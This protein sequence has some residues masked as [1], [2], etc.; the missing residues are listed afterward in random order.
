MKVIRPNCRVQFTAEDIDFILEVLGPRAGNNQT[1]VRL[2]ADEEARDLLLDDEAL[3]RAVLEQPHCLRVSTH[4]YFYLLVRHVLRRAHVLDRGVADYVAEILAE[5]SRTERMRYVARGHSQPLDYFVD[6][7][8]ALHQADEFTAFYLRAHI[9]DYSLFL[10][11][12]FPEHIRHRAAQRGAPDLSYYEQLGR[13]NYRAARDHRLASRYA[14]ADIFDVL[15]ERFQT[16]RLALNDLG[17]RLLLLGETDA[18]AA[19]LRP[20]SP[21]LGI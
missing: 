18:A 8:A 15:S 12:V 19:K 6:L 1:L 5:F 20:P 21:E 3:Y 4:F 16:T 7:L 10:A 11:G 13:S 9:G 17:E 14:L 2:L